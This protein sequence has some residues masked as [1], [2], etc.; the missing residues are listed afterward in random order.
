MTE[1]Q[2][3]R[4][5]AN[6]AYYRSEL[7]IEVSGQVVRYADTRAGWQE[8]DF[9]AMDK[10]WMRCIGRHKGDVTPMRA[11]LER[12]RGASKTSD[13][14]IMVCYALAFSTFP[15]KGIACSGDRDQARLLKDAIRRLCELNKWLGDVF[16]IQNWVVRCKITG[17][18]LEIMSSDAASGYGKL[19]DFILI[20]EIG[21]WADTEQARQ[22]WY[23]VSSTL[24][25]KANCLCVSITNAGR[26][27]SWQWEVREAIREDKNWY[28][29]AL[30]TVPSW[31][32]EE[33]L[34]EQQ[35]LLPPHVYTRLWGN[36]WTAGTDTGV[37]PADLE[38]CTVLLAEQ[39]RRLPMFDYYIAACDLGWRHDR[40]GIVVLAFSPL[41]GDIRLAY[42]ESWQPQ[43][44]G[45]ELP[46]RVVED[47]LWEIHKCF[48]LDS[49][50]FDPREA[51]GLS[52]RL[53]DRGVPCG[54]MNL[55]PDVQDNMAKVFLQA[56]NQRRVKLYPH[57]ELH[58][59]LLS[60]EVVDRTIGLKLQAAR[61]AGGH[62]DLG[63][64][65]A[66]ALLVA[67]EYQPVTAGDEVLFA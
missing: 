46:L 25:K 34:K 14:A 38:A 35:R 31:I 49:L 11:W 26:I 48:R 37:S 2:L 1:D 63:F 18:E 67:W 12:C 21:N 44:H 30:S 60:M 33:Q 50:V 28:F 43:D 42:C 39:E 4:M 62:S 23:V 32:T 7:N 8:A 47:A 27:D 5:A 55:S 45:G 52:Q 16:E 20:D 51:T 6:P 61:T 36:R 40:T 64:A 15:L 17:A 9:G 19:V 3:Q 10:A 53:C 22:F 57:S 29:H 24:T 54:R 66:M 59:D 56:F 58:K 41:R 65:F 13:Q